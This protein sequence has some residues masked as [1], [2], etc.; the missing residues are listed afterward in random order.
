MDRCLEATHGNSQDLIHASDFR[1][2]FW[3]GIMLEEE[4]CVG[5]TMSGSFELGASL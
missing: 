1:A 2:H 4:N 3:W 5:P